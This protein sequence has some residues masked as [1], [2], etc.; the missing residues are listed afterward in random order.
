LREIAIELKELAKEYQRGYG[1]KELSLT[2][3]AGSV[4][5]LLGPNGAGKTTTI[6]LL[7]GFMQADSGEAKIY[8]LDC[9]QDRTELK[10]YVS[11]LPGELR[12]LENLT[13]AEFLRLVEGLHENKQEIAINRTKLLKRLELN[14]E[15]PIRKMSKGMKQK[16][17]IVTALMTDKPVLLLDEPTSGLDPLMQQVFVEL[18]LEEKQK[19][20][21]I[22]M[23]SHHFPEVEKTCDQVGILRKG[24]LLALEKPSNLIA[25]E[26]QSFEVEVAREEDVAILQQSGLTLQPLDG[27]TF[28]IHVEGAPKALWQTLA[29]VEVKRFQQRR[30]ELEKAFLNYYQEQRGEQF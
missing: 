20:K 7:M 14:P 8:G 10:K 6:R 18:L 21:T 19:G 22:F 13:G 1:I 29:Q 28:A 15:M 26:R 11:Y 2:I 30:L 4:F 24:K 23:S 12:F 9:W 5:S 17:G 25:G 27:H 16:L 3:E